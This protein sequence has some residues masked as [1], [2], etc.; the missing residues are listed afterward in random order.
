MYNKNMERYVAFLR[1]INVGGVKVKMSDL[2]ACFETM[3]FQDVST[4][5]Q[6]GNVLFSAPKSEL[7][8]L[9]KQVEQN[10]SS[11]FR[12]TAF[13]QIFPLETVEKIVEAYPFELGPTDMHDYVIFFENNLSAEL[14]NETTA[15]LPEKIKPSEHALYWKV[16]KGMTLKSDFSKHL[17]KTKY[18]NF[19]TMRNIKTLQIILV[20]G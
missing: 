5:L 10:L 6:T 3:G 16:P 17:G 18:R 13:T 4:V 12:Y 11:T 1:G 15:N 14:V 2:R 20:A 19:N 7:S 9:K 8:H